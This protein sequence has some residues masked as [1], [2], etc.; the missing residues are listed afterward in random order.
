[1][2][3]SHRPRVDTERLRLP[4][5][6]ADQ[7]LPARILIQEG[8]CRPRLTDLFP[9]VFDGIPDRIVC[10]SNEDQGEVRL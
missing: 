1:M 3:P 8:K 10:G 2:L 7:S 5:S 6:Q 4:G 9:V